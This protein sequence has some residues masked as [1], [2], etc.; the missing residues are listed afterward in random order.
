MNKL[1]LLYIREGGG[2]IG[3]AWALLQRMTDVMERVGEGFC[4]AGD[5]SVFVPGNSH[6]M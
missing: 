1:L 6:W 2:L 3:L 4:V 5:W